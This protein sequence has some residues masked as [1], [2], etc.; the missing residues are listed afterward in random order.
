MSVGDITQQLDLYILA[1]RPTCTCSGLPFWIDTISCDETELLWE[2]LLG[3]DG[4]IL[5][6]YLNGPVGQHQHEVGVGCCYQ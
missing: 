5:C 4:I 6:T 1:T 3:D 2:L